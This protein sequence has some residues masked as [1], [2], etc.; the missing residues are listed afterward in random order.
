MTTDTTRPN[1]VLVSP[2][3][4]RL[5]VAQTD[6][7]ED[8]A[9]QLRS[10]IIASDGTL[11]AHTVLHDFGPHRGVDGMCFDEKG[12]I[13]ATAGWE[14][15]GPGPRLYVFTPDGAVR[16]VHPFPP[17]APTNCAFGD[18]GLR[19]LYVTAHD[20]CL[21]RARTDRTGSREF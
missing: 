8:Q 9:Q 13:V 20:G 16:D 14:R 5:F 6:Y 10:Y 12:N 2:A 17:S 1:G 3:Q 21:Y 7:R 11:G 18:D 15:S 19:T 4:D